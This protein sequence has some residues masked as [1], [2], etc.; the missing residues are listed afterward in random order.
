MNF[1]GS[2]DVLSIGF[3]NENDLHGLMKLSAFS[4][5]G[6]VGGGWLHYVTSAA[7]SGFAQSS[8]ASS[9]MGW[10]GV[11][12]GMRCICLEA[13]RLLENLPSASKLGN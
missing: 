7:S 9:L 10:E 3:G 13:F 12:R 11:V 6:Q 2:L 5:F 8:L 1:L 4:P